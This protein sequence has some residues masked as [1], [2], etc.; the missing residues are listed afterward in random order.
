MPGLKK[1]SGRECVKI[2]CNK[3]GFSIVRQS[4]SHVVLAKKT[5]EGRIG[6]VVPIHEELKIG[7]LKGILKL[8]KIK[9]EDF[10]RYQ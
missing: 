7:T 9:E 10:A 4:G 2:L 1:I 6:T 3:L 5:K 8:A